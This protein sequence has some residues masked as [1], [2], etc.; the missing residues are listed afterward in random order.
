MRFNFKAYEELF[1]RKEKPVVQPSGDP[2]DSMI[3]EIED[4]VE[5]KEKP[6]EVLEDGDTGINESDPE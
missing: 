4:E 5:V 2:E 6:K 3:N 1:P